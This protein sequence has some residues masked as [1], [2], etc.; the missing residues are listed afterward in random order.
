MN[1]S[2]LLT[3]PEFCRRKRQVN[4]AVVAFFG[5]SFALGCLVPIAG[6]LARLVMGPAF[7]EWTVLPGIGVTIVLWV[8]ALVGGV[9]TGGVLIRHR[10]LVCHHCGAALTDTAG[11]SRVLSPGVCERCGLPVFAD[12]ASVDVIRNSL[13]WAIN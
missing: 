5:I 6:W 8:A 12:F 9:T 7:P 11:R 4:V 10:G 3:R 1:G 13:G 2:D